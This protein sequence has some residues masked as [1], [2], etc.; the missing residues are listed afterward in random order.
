MRPFL[1]IHHPTRARKYY[2]SG[3]WTEDTFYGL[4]A[5]H[6]AQRPDAIALQDGRRKLSWRQLCQMVDGVAADLREY[7]LIGG[8]RVSIW[9]SNRIEAV[10]MFLACAREGLA[11]NPSLHKTYTCAEICEL[12][13][14]LSARALLTEPGWGADRSRVD[15]DAMLVRIPSL[16][17]V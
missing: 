11:C 7:G 14:S 1:T 9:M 16:K 15:L 3:L 13:T 5:R 12:L 8:D 6:A 4:L 17:A 2:E 10:V